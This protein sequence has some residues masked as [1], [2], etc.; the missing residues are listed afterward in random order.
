MHQHSTTT[1]IVCC[2]V[3]LIQMQYLSLSFKPHMQ[4]LKEAGDQKVRELAADMWPSFMSLDGTTHMIFPL[5]KYIISAVWIGLW[6][7]CTII[8]DCNKF[9]PII[10]T[11][12]I[13]F[14][15]LTIIYILLYFSIFILYRYF[16]G[17]D[18]PHIV[19]LSHLGFSTTHFSRHRQ[20][21]RPWCPARKP[22]GCHPRSL[23]SL[24]VQRHNQGRLRGDGDGWV[25][26]RKPFGQEGKA[27]FFM[28]VKHGK[29]PM[30]GHNTELL[31]R[32]TKHIFAWWL[33]RWIKYIF[34]EKI[35][36]TDD[37]SDFSEG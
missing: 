22:Q 11:Y 29:N 23:R 6:Q 14:N 2:Y 36:P 7:V 35:I 28:V 27:L 21:R 12:I 5:Y 20:A 24:G 31:K 32:N 34:Q 17:D 9:K 1:K 18:S 16:F 19:T 4:S 10:I 37:S 25:V 30:I 15:R 26:N 8:G 3:I 33:R 13:T